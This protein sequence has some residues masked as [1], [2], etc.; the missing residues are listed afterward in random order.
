MRSLS[1]ATHT[2]RR[3]FV[4]LGAASIAAAAIATCKPRRL[5]AAEKPSDLTRAT[6]KELAALIRQKDASALEVVDACLAR[7]AQVNPKLNA[8]VALVA[9][10]ARTKARAADQAL[11]RGEAVG[12]LHGV[13][14]TIKDSL[15]TAS[16]VTTAGTWGRKSFV[17]KEDATVVK[18][19]KE[20]GAILLGKT[21]TPEVT[22][23]F[24][25]DNPVYG[26]TNNPWNVNLSPGGSSGGAGA[27]VAAGGVPFD[28]G[29]DTG[30]SIRV[31]SHFCGVTGIK[32]T[33]GRTPRTGHII[34]A[35]GHLQAF[36]QLGPIARSVDD[37]ALI[38]GL[39]SGP[40]FRDATVVPFPLGDSRQVSIKGLRVAIHTDN[41]ART[42]HPEVVKAVVDTAKSLESAGV[43]IEAQR[44]KALDDVLTMDDDLYRADGA[45]ALQR[46]LANA[47]TTAPGPDVLAALKRQPMTSGELT[48]AIERWDAW[49]GRML[50]FL[51]DFDAILCPPC[52]FVELPHGTSALADAN[53]AFSYTFAY[54]MTGWPAAVV[55]A[56]TSS[57]GL[58]IGVQIIGRPWREDVVLA[59]AGEVER[60]LGGFQPPPI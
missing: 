37:L 33:S 27:I 25:T 56:G 23:A 2:S 40:D 41:G 24:E 36:T 38:L 11:T 53:A 19:L 52:A 58:P 16:V 21:N 50:Q 34:S 13:P 43:R 45:A 49:R 17:P 59:L 3:T 30:G 54:N 1:A 5:P 15:D 60:R 48:A 31:P 14:M 22:W 12:P 7:I 47:G 51:A 4:S 35:E 28:I 9:E 20:A 42:P 8:V 55:R 39:I 46:L 32:P 6:A 26:R 18:R 44:P 10:N 29:S 57:S